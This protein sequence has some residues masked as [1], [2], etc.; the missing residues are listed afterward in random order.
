MY[1]GIFFEKKIVLTDDQFKKMLARTD[2]EAATLQGGKY[3]FSAEAICDPYYKEDCKGCPLNQGNQGSKEA[4]GCRALMESLGVLPGHVD[5]SDPFCVS[6]NAVDN[7][8][9]G[10]ELAALRKFLKSGFHK[11]GHR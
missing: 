4:L 3:L 9:A 7:S 11:G 5:L 6:W 10:E 2:Y 8:V 1:E